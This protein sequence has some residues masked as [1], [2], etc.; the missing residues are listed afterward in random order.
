MGAKRNFAPMSPIELRPRFR[1]KVEKFIR[2]LRGVSR[3]Y[4]PMPPI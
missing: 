1:Y 3:F 4:A 2:F